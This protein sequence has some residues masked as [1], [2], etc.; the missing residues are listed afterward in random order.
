MVSVG[1]RTD[2]FLRF[3]KR[4]IK[5]IVWIVSIS[6]QNLRDSNDRT[7]NLPPSRILFNI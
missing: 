4:Y 6:I 3:F 5:F 2:I 7:Q 1:G